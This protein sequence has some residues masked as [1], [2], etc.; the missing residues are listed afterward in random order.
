MID[1]EQAKV[2]AR[3]VLRGIAA[4]APLL[5]KDI[6]AERINALTD[7]IADAIQAWF[8]VL[9][10]RAFPGD[11]AETLE[12]QEGNRAKLE[13][14]ILS[15]CAQLDIARDEMEARIKAALAGIAETLI[16]PIMRRL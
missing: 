16:G 13:A 10:D 1:R 11:D 8:A 14:S 7:R 12:R 3:E 15:V 2:L 4:A 5:L 9:W 6:S